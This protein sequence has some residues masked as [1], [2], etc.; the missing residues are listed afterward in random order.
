ML[1]A[2]L[3]ALAER[4]VPRARRRVLRISERLED[5]AW[6]ISGSGSYL[7]EEAGVGLLGGS[8][9]GDA[10]AG[11]LRISYASPIENLEEALRRLRN[12]LPKYKD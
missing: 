2:G 5:H 12:A 9:F 1:V 8:C 11:Y 4:D 6:T 10:G 7:L 3:N